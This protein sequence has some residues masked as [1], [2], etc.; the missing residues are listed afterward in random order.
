MIIGASGNY[1]KRY[2]VIVADRQHGKYFT[3]YHDT[4]EDKGE[5]FRN[6]FVPQ[7]VKAEGFRTGKIGHHIRDHLLR[8]LKEVGKKALNFVKKQ[9]IV[10]TGGVVIGGHGEMLS[11]IR[12]Y[13]PEDLR[14]KVIGY[15]ITT[16]DLPVGELADK[17]K[18][19]I[20]PAEEIQQKRMIQFQL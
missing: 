4:W 6:I 20:N 14:K 10:V 7:K 18:Q 12:K 17:A 2:L 8:H 13:L 11:T 19:V 3:I 16:T 1:S 9:K 15:F 5:E